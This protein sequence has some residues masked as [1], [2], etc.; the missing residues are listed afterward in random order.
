MG[1]LCSGGAELG[2]P[3]DLSDIDNFEPFEANEWFGISVF[4]I[5]LMI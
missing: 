1:G 2:E 5:V 4:V 3:C